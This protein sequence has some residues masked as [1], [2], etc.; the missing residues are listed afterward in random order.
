MLSTPGRD[1]TAAPHAATAR[2]AAGRRRTARLVLAGL[3]Q[4]QVVALGIVALHAAQTR[5][6]DLYLAARE[7]WRS[8]ELAAAAR[9]YGTFARDYADETW[10]VKLRQNYPS[11]AS[12]WF[13]LGRIEAERGRTDAALEAFRRAMRLEPGRGR[14]EYRDLLLERGRPAEL[15]A[16]AREELA[17]DAAATIAWW[18]L[19]AAELA[20][21]RPAAAVQAYDRALL[22]LPALLARVGTAPPDE[23]SGEEADLVNLRAI[24][25][26]KAGDLAG[27]AADCEGLGDRQPPGADLDRLC[28]AFLLQAAGR[29]DAARE[30]LK[31][32]QPIGPEHDALVHELRARIGSGSPKE[33]GPER[34]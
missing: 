2:V 4:V 19:G 20:L 34:R 24:A 16:L 5:H 27:A 29:G 18:D 31:G 3:V 30:R 23:L 6:I 1:A 11:E 12:A 15:A 10:P 17:R 22:H 9:D 13:A 32:Y 7:A 26:L 25:R 21:G 28:S 33:S 8:G 14:R